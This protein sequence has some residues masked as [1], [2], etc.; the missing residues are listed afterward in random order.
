MSFIALLL[1]FLVTVFLAILAFF[2]ADER[3]LSVISW[4][5]RRKRHP[6]HHQVAE[7]RGCAGTGPLQRRVI[8]DI[9]KLL[10]RRGWGCAA[11]A[12]HHPPRC[13]VAERRRWVWV[14]VVTRS[15]KTHYHFF[16]WTCFDVL[17]QPRGNYDAFATARTGCSAGREWLL[18]RKHCLGRVLLRLPL[19]C[20]AGG[21]VLLR[22]YHRRSGRHSKLARHMTAASILRYFRSM[23]QVVRQ[24][25]APGWAAA[26]R[27]RSVV[28][29]AAGL[30]VAK[31]ACKT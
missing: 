23:P 7:R 1:D 13:Q 19:H 14:G 27:R 9:I 6:R 28:I 21:R 17:L 18:P 31:E 8:H 12:R 4:N 20:R 15:R 10:T 16:W 2:W 3:H 22:I 29:I 5:R 11:A 26:R 24:A 25:A 30:S